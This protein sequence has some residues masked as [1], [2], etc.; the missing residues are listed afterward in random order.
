MTGLV[1]GLDEDEVRRKLRGRNASEL[2]ERGLIVGTPTEVK[3][4]LERL[5]EA[6]LQRV[7]LQWLD[8]D[9]LTGLEALARAV[10]PF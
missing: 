9:D 8:P 7:M 3:R 5:A 10:L 4:Q 1:F 6:G 2:M